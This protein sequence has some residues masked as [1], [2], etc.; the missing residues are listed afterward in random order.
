MCLY[1]GGQGN[2]VSALVRRHSWHGPLHTPEQEA[3]A[4][5]RVAA[6]YLVRHQQNQPL[7]IDI[8]RLSL[9]CS[10]GSMWPALKG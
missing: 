4:H 8:W 10:N 7:S 5:I 1:S 9:H 3:P 2:V 6:G